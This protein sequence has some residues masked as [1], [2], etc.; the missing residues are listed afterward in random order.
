METSFV[1][2]SSFEGS[3]AF[4][5]S[6]EADFLRKFYLLLHKRNMVIFGLFGIIAFIFLS[7]IFEK[8]RWLVVFSWIGAAIFAFCALIVT[9]EY[10]FSTKKIKDVR[11]KHVVVSVVF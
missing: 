2:V 8:N 9:C 10:F 4:H 1:D 7:V 5:V 6:S 3:E 11:N